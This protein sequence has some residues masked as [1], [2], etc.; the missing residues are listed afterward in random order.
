[1]AKNALCMLRTCGSSR[2]PAKVSVK[3]P[4][5]AI[6]F[7]SPIINIQV[8]I[9]LGMKS[10]LYLS[11]LLGSATAAR[12]G[13]HGEEASFADQ[14]EVVEE[15]KLSDDEWAGPTEQRRK[16]VTRIVVSISFEIG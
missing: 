16:Y 1:M 6:S 8:L 15:G 4:F 7:N 13:K 10:L 12:L 14:L 2:Y 3:I 11:F 5:S 9:D